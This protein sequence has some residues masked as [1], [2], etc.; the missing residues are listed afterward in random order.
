[1]MITHHI[2]KDGVYHRKKVTEEHIVIVIEPGHNF[3]G[4]VTP[5]DGTAKSVGASIQMFVSDSNID[6]RKLLAVGC[7]G[8]NVNTGW[9]NGKIT[10]L[11]NH[12]GYALHWFLCF[13]HCNDH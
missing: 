10:A 9:K 12:V 2:L 11:E 1:M 5:K 6:P 8:T 13:S 3:L 4:H 7:D